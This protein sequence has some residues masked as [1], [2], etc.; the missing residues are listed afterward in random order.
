ML[1]YIYLWMCIIMRIGKILQMNYEKRRDYMKRLIQIVSLMLIL[2]SLL[3][4]CSS[5]KEEKTISNFIN[6][7]IS[8]KTYEGV[9]FGEDPDKYVEES[10]VSFGE[11]LTDEA[12]DTLMA[13][14]IPNFYY[15][16]IN[17]NN[18]NDITD[19][20][21]VKSKET[22]NDTYIHYEYE[23]SYKLKAGD[24]SLDMT[25]YMV[26]KVMEDNNSFIDEVH[27]LDKTS[28]IFSEFKSIVQ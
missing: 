8:V 9:T 7:L 20:K 21:I 16:V 24:K 13:N 3:V 4:G 5:T 27:V 6:K 11:Y 22:K 19:I 26:F 25:D 14:R 12:F 18:V 17:K 1:F 28:S 10:K 2:L 15:T 23:V